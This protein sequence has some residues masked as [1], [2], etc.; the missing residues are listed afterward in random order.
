MV[1]ENL[2][3]I[4]HQLY[5]FSYLSNGDEFTKRDHE[6]EFRGSKNGGR[7]VWVGLKWPENAE[8]Q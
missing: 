2:N 7:E 6:N 5:F 4:V 8:N 3:P 1:A